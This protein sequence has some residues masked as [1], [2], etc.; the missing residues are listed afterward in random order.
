MIPPLALL[1]QK[2]VLVPVPSLRGG[3]IAHPNGV[4]VGGGP[5][6]SSIQS[7]VSLQSSHA[8]GKSPPQAGPC[9]PPQPQPTS[10]H[11]PAV[12]A[13]FPRVPVSGESRL[14][15]AG[16]LQQQAVSEVP[17][18]SVPHCSQLLAPVGSDSRTQHAPITRMIRAATSRL[19]LHGAHRPVT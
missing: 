8:K 9:Q 3:F 14:F 7:S 13:G 12:Q 16:S 10:G 11:L 17:A 2:P 19:L 1:G 6:G 4:R 5:S 15:L 18:L